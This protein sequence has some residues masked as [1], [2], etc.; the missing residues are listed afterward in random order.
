M[1]NVDEMLVLIKRLISEAKIRTENGYITDISF[2]T[3]D[4]K[5]MKCWKT[6]KR[7]NIS[8]FDQEIKTQLLSFLLKTLMIE[9]H[10]YFCDISHNFYSVIEC[11]GCFT[12]ICQCDR[13]SH[14]S[15]PCSLCDREFCNECQSV[16]NDLYECDYSMFHCEKCHINSN[17][18]CE[19]KIF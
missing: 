4:K 8:S 2:V 5:L 6:L 9:E 3:D 17:V 19:Y 16:T 15:S 14:E 1:D 18:C 10:L 7:R 11:S 13:C 12:S